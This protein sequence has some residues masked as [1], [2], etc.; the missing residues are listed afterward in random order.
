MKEKKLDE[1]SALAILFANTRRKKRK[2]DLITIARAFEYLVNLYGSKEAVAKRVGL[3]TEMIREFLTV[4]KLPR[5]IQKLVTERIIDRVDIIRKISV[6]KEPP[7]QIAAAHAFINSSS[8]DVRDIQ[9][10]VK[11]ANLPIRDAKKIVLEAK[12]KGLHIFV[13][14]FDDEMYQ[15]IIGYAKTLK[16]KPAEL[17]RKMVTDWLKQK[18]K[19]D[20]KHAAHW[21]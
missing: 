21:L 10:L 11:D 19:I 17:V 14:D 8:E 4:L 20:K 13:M 2:E 15:E 16:V 12:P 1:E 18:A 5:E 3:S 6:I 7:K 9:R